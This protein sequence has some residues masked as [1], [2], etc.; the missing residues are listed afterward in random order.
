M[1][2]SVE[3]PC[4]Y[5]MEQWRHTSLTLNLKKWCIFPCAL[6]LGKKISEKHQIVYQCSKKK[7]WNK[8]EFPR[9]RPVLVAP[10]IDIRLF[11]E[12]RTAA[13]KSTFLFK[14][15]G[16]NADRCFDIFLKSMVAS[17]TRQVSLQLHTGRSLLNNRN[18]NQVTICSI[19]TN[20]N[21]MTAYGKRKTHK[22][23]FYR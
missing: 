16:R 1:H 9:F 11:K 7:S 17:Q 3:P 12:I 20:T 10:Q 15:T 4:P 2:S 21:V 5:F 8:I 23:I 6:R 18:L 22:I 14:G 19:M 13:R